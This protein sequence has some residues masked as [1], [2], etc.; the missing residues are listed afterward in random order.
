MKRP[1]LKLGKP[2]VKVPAVVEN[3]YRD[4]RD[5]RLLPLVVLLLVAIVAVPIALSAG[6][7]SPTTSAPA[8]EIVPADAP[9]A[10]AAVLADNP[11]LRDYRKRLHALKAQNPFK[12]RFQTSGLSGTEVESGATSVDSVTSS[13]GDVATD[14]GSSAPAT[15]TSSGS[16]STSA[17]PPDSS[18]GGTVDADGAEP[19][20]FF[21]TFKADLQYGL[22]GDVRERR[23]VKYLDML[24]PVGTFL[25][26]TL[27][28]RTAVFGLSSSIVSVSGE[29]D[30]VPSPDSCEF[31]SLA[32]GK[33]AVLTYQRPGTEPAAYRLAV[34]DIRVV[35][36]EEPP[37]V[38]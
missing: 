6:G 20:V 31:L 27:D 9:E 36:V 4:L 28:R 30:C 14:T 8:A 26:A 32:K 16:T 29:G 23:N 22:E 38:E 19:E 1:E 3:V 33:S 21:Y 37:V 35:K 2:D 10:Q 13:G 15:S 25:G 11:G 34:D 12:Q 24:S 17:S 18:G 5:R 7:S